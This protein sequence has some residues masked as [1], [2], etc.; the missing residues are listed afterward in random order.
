MKRTLLAIE[1]EVSQGARDR[2]KRHVIARHVFF[3]QAEDGI[4]YLTV[5]GVQTCALP[6]FKR[7]SETAIQIVDALDG[8]LSDHT[9]GTGLSQRDVEAVRAVLAEVKHA[10]LQTSDM[11]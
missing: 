7:Q 2:A 10:S 5:T 9:V 3:F 4:R 6:I 1:K 8:A 11:P